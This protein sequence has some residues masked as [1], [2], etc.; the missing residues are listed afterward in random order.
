MVRRPDSPLTRNNRESL[1][2]S[3]A[4]AANCCQIFSRRFTLTG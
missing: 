1:T 3:A 2:R 4:Y